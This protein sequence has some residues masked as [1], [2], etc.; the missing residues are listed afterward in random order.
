MVQAKAPSSFALVRSDGRLISDV[1][2]NQLS[3]SSQVSLPTSPAC[4]LLQLSA[5]TILRD[6]LLAEGYRISKKREMGEAA[7]SRTSFNSIGFRGAELEDRTHD[8]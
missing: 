4:S 8:Y 6:C 2:R 5:D 3:K 1:V 7:A